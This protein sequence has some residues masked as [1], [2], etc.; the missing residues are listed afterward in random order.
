MLFVLYPHFFPLFYTANTN[1]TGNKT[2]QLTTGEEKTQIFICI[3]CI[4]LH[5]S[6]TDLKQ[7]L[8]MSQREF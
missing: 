7:E 6:S 8:F 2:Q 5:N 4:F 1:S 3:L